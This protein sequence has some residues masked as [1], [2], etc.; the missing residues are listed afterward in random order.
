[1][2][3]VLKARIVGDISD[4]KAK[5]AEAEKVTEGFEQSIESTQKSVSDLDRVLA[6][7]IREVAS[8]NSENSKS[9][10]EI[11]ALNDQL[12]KERANIQTLTN[13]LQNLKKESQGP[14]KAVGILEQLNQK[15]RDLKKS[16]EEGTNLLAIARL[17]KQL[18]A[19]EQ[20]IDRIKAL[21]RE[22]AN[23]ATKIQGLTQE[24]GN[25]T[26]TF[27]ELNRVIQDAPFGIIGVGNNLQQLA[28][29]FGQLSQQAGGT[30]AALALTFK[31]L[32][33][34][35]NPAI[36][37]VSAITTAF[38]LYQM[39][40][41]GS[42]DATK[43]LVE[44][45]DDFKKGLDSSNQARLQGLADADKEIVTLGALRSVIENETLSRD[46]RLSAIDQA[47]K[48]FPTLFQGLETEKILAG[49]VGDSYDRLTKILIARATAQS[50]I[51]KIVQL[52]DEERLINEKNA[53]V[54]QRIS[55]FEEKAAKFRAEGQ[56]ELATI[57]EN[58]I[59]FLQNQNPELA[60]LVEIEKERNTL[61]SLVNEN[62]AQSVTLTSTNTDSV[63]TQN[64]ELEKQKRIYEDLSVLEG[65]LERAALE[66]LDTFS[67]GVEAPITVTSGNADTAGIIAKNI[68]AIVGQNEKLQESL[69]GTGITVEQFFASI[70]MGAASGFSSLE[71]FISK[72]SETQVAFDQAS[73]VLE[74]GIENS[75]GNVAFAIG[76]A[77]A[78]GGNVFKAGGQALLGSFAS[79][80]DQLG[81]IAI[82]VGIGI[83]AIK[84]ALK[85]L[86][87]VVAI[88]AGVALITLA[89][90]ARGGI[91][92]IGNSVGS[93]SI[94]AGEGATFTNRRE[95]GGPVAAGRAY[96]VGEK[97]P[98]IF[99]PNTN[100]TIIPKMPDMN[101]GGMA[102][103]RAS[104]MNVNLSG[105]FR[106][107]KNDLLY[108]I[109]QGLVERRLT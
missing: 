30:R 54:I 63:K 33:S 5:M 46:K 35:I 53:E 57:Q 95:F 87:P 31:S 41:F 109:E 2:E 105:S 25:A 38:T 79:I 10:V 34:G 108:V 45:L 14:A 43:S 52:A 42:K 71:Q 100:G 55:G 4:Y 61:T 32:I 73:K 13:A 15:A 75:I 28:G 76:E 72:L 84:A 102:N 36:L 86:N 66:R 91:K 16:I 97:R 23:S 101:Y 93:G 39:G 82:G 92:N 27:Q 88:A 60:R 98:E 50:S 37:A 48:Q 67:K 81:Q 99:V 107:D 96:I 51:N 64:T 74:Q 59:R 89:G 78:S 80:L 103:G 70:G 40:V 62:L 6:L 56:T 90:I 49:E 17:N 26:G 69:Q 44:Q 22:S 83:E 1:M 65:L 20:K 24:A 18:E 19:T 29:N 3:N 106:I 68:S 9:K 58:Q 47:N 8:L 77:L 12:V 11:Q 94:S 21:G 7:L 104:G 85:T